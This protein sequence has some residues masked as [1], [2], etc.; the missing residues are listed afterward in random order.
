MNQPT[1][2]PESYRPAPG[3]FDA[4]D[5]V[6]A[7]GEDRSSMTPETVQEGTSLDAEIASAFAGM[8]AEDLAELC[9][10]GPT[11]G[12]ESTPT[13]ASTVTA[14]TALVGTIVGLSD[15]E[16]FLE[17]DAKS[18]GILPRSQFG[19]K[20]P[21][22]IGRRVDVTVERYDGESGL[23]VVNRKGAAQRASWTTLTIGNIVEGRVTG[24]NK[25]GLEIDLQGVRAF[26]PGS[27]CDLFPMR[28]ISV[29]IGQSVRAEVIELDRRHKSVLVSRRKLMERERAESRDKLK[30]ELEVGQTRRGVVGNLTE[31]G[32]FVDLGGI[33]GLIHIRD[34][35]WG[36]V[37]KV[38][39]VLKTGQ[40]IEVKIL[41]I[42]GKRDRVSLGLKQALPD[43]WLNVAERYSV[44][45]TLK[46]RVVRIAD[47]GAF[48][49][50]EPGI[51]GLI[52][53]SEMGWQ[54]IHS[55]TD[56]VSVGSVVDVKVV[57]IE[58]ER[59]R[60]TL[61]I[62]QAQK[63]PW[64]G[65]LE[66]FTPNSTIRGTVTRLANFGAFV[67]IAPGVEGLVHISELSDKRVRSAGDVVNVGNE[68][69]VRVLGVDRENRRISLSMKPTHES[70]DHA[71]SAAS[72]SA[73]PMKEKKRKKPLRGGLASHWE[74]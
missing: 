71:A 55:P 26:M 18:Q 56:V 54:R 29:L 13:D 69:D 33:D 52:P 45:S 3:D 8:A 68:V 60:I 16:V 70:G 41:K 4:P 53:V 62:K 48:A 31:F 12:G 24:L 57:R 50:I 27:Q 61:S 37:E 22:D 38:S 5:G 9:G 39:D 10:Q 30:A 51:D 40:E 59:R 64:E 74:W 32:A 2:I 17:F 23:L 46:A 58:P 35:S 21:V 7:V 72:A 34:L 6:G 63:D 19:K 42:D 65:V 36:T 67:Q 44:D 20:E 73:A 47:F 1:G 15:D 14:G 11:P 66:S 43:P 25:G 28:D 49:E